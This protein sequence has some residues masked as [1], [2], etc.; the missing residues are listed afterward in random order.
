MKD[1]VG[2]HV[3]DEINDQIWSIALGRMGGDVSAEWASSM[4]GSVEFD[5]QP[6]DSTGERSKTSQVVNRRALMPEFFKELPPP[7]PETGVSGVFITPYTGTYSHTVP[8]G[9][10]AKVR[11]MRAKDVPDFVPRPQAHQ[12]LPPWQEADYQRL[13]LAPEPDSRGK[14]GVGASEQPG[15][16]RV[17]RPD[18]SDRGEGTGR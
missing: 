12:E 2:E 3:A 8:G 7:T 6:T 16:L 18:T 15:R 1:A 4:V 11:A 9:E 13:G 10:I 5:E 17:V 14:G